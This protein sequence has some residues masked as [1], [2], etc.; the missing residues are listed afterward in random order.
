[1]L[2]DED[3]TG[4]GNNDYRWSLD[5]GDILGTDPGGSPRRAIWLSPTYAL[6]DGN[7]AQRYT[8]LNTALS[9]ALTNTQTT[10]SAEKD[11]YDQNGG[12]DTAAIGQ[13]LEIGFGWRDQSSITNG[14]VLVD[15]FNFQGLLDYDEADITL[16]P[17]PSSIA[18]ATL[19]LLGLLGCRWR[20]RR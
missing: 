15:N 17:E 19:G 8:Q 18:I 4:W 3:L 12:A 9:G 7:R 5:Y 1:M 20:R 10:T 11:A 13:P 16:V 2:P 6:A 14:P